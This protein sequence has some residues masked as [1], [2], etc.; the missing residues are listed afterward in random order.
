MKTFFKITGILFFTFALCP[1]PCSFSN[2]PQLPEFPPLTFHPPKPARYQ[3]AN[4]LTVFLLEDHELPLIRVQMLIRAGSEYD[5]PEKTGLSEIFGE[6]LTLGGSQHYTPEQIQRGLETAGAT[7]SFAVSM[8]STSASFTCR[9]SDFDRFFP[10]FTDVLEH[11]L[12][13]KDFFEVAKSKQYEALRRMNDDPAD[14]C[15]REFHKAA[16]GKDHPYAR[17]PT[18]ET[19]D[20]IKRDDLLEMHARYFHPNNSYIAVS[21]DFSADEIK[22]KLE[23]SLGSWEK[24]EVSFPS[25]PR[26]QPTTARKVF[27]V[28]QPITQTQIRIGGTGFARLSPDHFAWE[29]FDELWGGSGTSRMFKV[30][31]TQEGL[32][33]AVGSAFS[34]PEDLGLIVAICQTRGPESPAAI[35]AILDIM[36][37][38]KD[39]PFT[40]KEIVSAKESIRNRF[41]ENFT[42]SAQI[43]GEI[44]RLEYDGYPSDYLDTYT[45]KIGA[46]TREDLRRVAQKYLHPEQS[47]IMVVGDLSLFSKPIS[48]FGQP[49]PIKLE[50]YTEE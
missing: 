45:E 4:G 49:I 12:F 39:A 17:T 21:G 36:G 25:V 9:I 19:L 33:Y 10:I 23:Q 42:S 5:P 30:I 16:Y 46:V 28:E 3:M 38:V 24:K 50:N 27:Y 43:A 14:V 41:V 40:D 20:H 37:E 7:M 29:V 48:T 34:E 15:R 2:P 35:Q 13:R 18:P 1:L 11:P 44:M 26:V 31:R 47:I 8:E 32:A 22:R 6:A